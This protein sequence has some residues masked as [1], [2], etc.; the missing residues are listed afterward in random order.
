[1]TEVPTGQPAEKRYPCKKCGKDWKEH[2]VFHDAP[3]PEQLE[4]LVEAE[5]DDVEIHGMYCP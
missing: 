1:M 2:T 3:T 5:F 4:G